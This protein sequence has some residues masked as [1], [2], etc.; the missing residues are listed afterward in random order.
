[1]RTERVLVLAH[2][3][4]GDINLIRIGAYTNVGENVVIHEAF[5][6]LSADHDG[7]SIVGHYCSIGAG[8]MLRA[9]TIEDEVVVGAGSVLLDGAYVE[10]GSILGRGSRVPRNV[11]IPSGQLWA[12][13][14]VRYVR[15]LTDRERQWII[16]SAIAHYTGVA[17]DYNQMFFLDPHAYIEKVELG[18]ERMSLVLLLLAHV[19]DAHT[20]SGSSHSTARV[21]AQGAAAARHSCAHISVGR[22]FSSTSSFCLPWRCINHT[23]YNSQFV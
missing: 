6:P 3:T 12:G 16:R 19:L 4:A 20:L 11:R 15:H 14:P 13:S 8:S 23:P 9:V 1:M 18:L 22:L 2:T 7:S 21:H 5:E 17:A 10:A